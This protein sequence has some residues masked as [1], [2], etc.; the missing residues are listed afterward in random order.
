MAG[1]DR[2]RAPRAACLAAGAAWLLTL[3]WA[4]GPADVRAQTP[5]QV[6]AGDRPGPVFQT[7][8]DCVACH[9]GLMT[10]TGEDVSIGTSWR[11]S[12]MAQSAR[13]PYWQGAVRRETIDHPTHV[14][15]IEDECSIC[16]MPMTTAPARARGEH[17]EIFAHLPI[18]ADDSEV[19]RLAADGVSCTVCHQITGEG[20]GSRESFTGGYVLSVV[21]PGSDQR[22]PPPQPMFGPFE[23]KP[24]H[25]HLMRSSTG[26][27]PTE[28][29]H[30]RQSELCATCHTL[31]TQALDAQ[32]AVVG[33]LPE[34]VPYLEWQHSAFRDEHSCQA[35]HMPAVDVPT[36][37]TSVLGEPREGLG[38]HT[39]RGGNFFMLR[40]LNRYR[41]DLGV[42]VPP[43]DLEASARATERQLQTETATV[44]ITE[45]SRTGADVA[46]T[47][48]VT[49]QVGHKLPTGY[50][51]R[52]VWLHVTVLDEAR[53]TVFESGAVSP[54][55]AIRG[56]DNDADGWSVE[57][58]YQ[59]IRSPDEVQIY[60]SVMT[61]AAG[62][63]TTGLLSGVAYVKDNR[64]L[65]RGFD[66]TVASDDI[67]VR[68]RAA[69][70]PDFLG[71]GD[72]V[73][74]VVNTPTAGAL[75]VEA[76]LRYQPIGY[77][78]ARNLGAYDAMETQRFVSY[79]DAM[80]AG[81]SLVLARA[82][83]SVEE[84]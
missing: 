22:Q 52:R 73:R 63:V 14:A 51:S 80:A 56:N 4:S 54:D 81:S 76:E 39:F 9:N 43:A 50:P 62:A 31:F 40:M 66:K 28:G 20:F 84:R 10:P 6:G 32:G 18:G 83:A 17:G 21:P 42:G 29:A 13:D 49:S 44:A 68:G 26:V 64:L 55:G 16:H 82:S 53:R 2:R 1:A 75:T 30:V 12:M 78:W 74:Y 37:I 58:H 33:T 27:T 72:R 46:F 24:G 7:S 36:P 41:A 8:H 59:E 38:R 79:Y 60:E 23:V 71:S 70:D 61:D 65:P 69:T 35:C 19:G 67:A 48:S 45:T 34:Q 77:R 47:V 11:A 3:L 25:A 15:A 5:T 57:P